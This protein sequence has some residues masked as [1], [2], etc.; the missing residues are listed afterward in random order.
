MKIRAEG[1]Y[2]EL[3]K[4]IRQLNST[5]GVRIHDESK[6]YSN[7]RGSRPEIENGRIYLEIELKNLPID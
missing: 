1:N 5:A 3:R 7:D 6:F 4:F 2:T